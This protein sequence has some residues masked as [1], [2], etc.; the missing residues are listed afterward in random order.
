MKQRHRKLNY[1]SKYNFCF[2]FQKTQSIPI[3]EYGDKKRNNQLFNSLSFSI[4]LAVV[5]TD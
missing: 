2:F 5:E 1:H 3:Y 4:G